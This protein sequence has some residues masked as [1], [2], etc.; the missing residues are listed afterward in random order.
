MKKILMLGLGAKPDADADDDETEAE[1]TDHEA[2]F[3]A[4][5]KAAAKAYIEACKEHTEESE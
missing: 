5:V 1:G 4:A 3:L 2:T